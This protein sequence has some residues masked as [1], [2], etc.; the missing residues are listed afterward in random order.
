MAATYYYANDFLV[1]HMKL[2]ALL[3]LASQILTGLPSCPSNVIL[4]IS[5]LLRY[6][7]PTKISTIYWTPLNLAFF[8]IGPVLILLLIT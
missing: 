7:G 6:P 2:A 3:F 4:L 8:E 5:L 1:P